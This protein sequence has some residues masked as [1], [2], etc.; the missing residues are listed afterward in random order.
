VT[1]RFRWNKLDDGSS[2]YLDVAGNVQCDTR[3]FTLRTV[4]SVNRYGEPESGGFTGR[5]SPDFASMTATW[6]NGCTLSAKKR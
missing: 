1:G 6:D 2:F 4:N 5:F 3:A